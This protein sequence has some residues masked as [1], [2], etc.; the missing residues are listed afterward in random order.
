M[1][2]NMMPIG[3]DYVENFRNLTKKLLTRQK[4][5]HIIMSTRLM[6]NLD[7]QIRLSQQ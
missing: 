1:A 2:N 6:N 4:I 7:H 5:S 3:G